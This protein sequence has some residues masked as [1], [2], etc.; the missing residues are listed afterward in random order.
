VT[1]SDLVIG[2]ERI[3][4]TKL[5]WKSEVQRVMKQK[6]LTTEGLVTSRIWKKVTEYW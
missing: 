6:R 1:N 3:R 4:K 5:K 2:K